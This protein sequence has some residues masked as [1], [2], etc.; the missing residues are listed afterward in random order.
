M[1]AE[2]AHSPRS[3]PVVF[4]PMEALRLALPREHGSWSL[5]LEPLALG[6]LVAPSRAGIPL[7]LA[8]VAGFFLRRPVKL[9]LQTKPDPR[10]PLAVFGVGTLLLLAAAALLLAAQ[11]GGAARLWPLVPA[12]LTGMIFMWF[13]TR[14]ENRE[15]L[16]ELAGVTAFALL[17]A[18][19][20][21]LAGWRME[22]ALALA[23]VMLARSAPTVLAVRTFLRRRKG[24]SVSAMPARLAALAATGGLCWLAALSLVPWPVAAFSL[25]LA[26]RTF[27]FGSAAAA[28]LSARRLGFVELFLGVA[29][30][31]V[32][33]ATWLK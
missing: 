32:A 30:V 12:L 5:A 10:R 11:W 27:W 14:G 31:I 8:A 21:S 3:F 29:A 26:A 33:A 6:L 23:A 7:A 25:L 16:A 17:P 1:S 28:R 4:R 24:E 22:N 15:G 13:D 18:A 20:A 2:L 9:L 19:F